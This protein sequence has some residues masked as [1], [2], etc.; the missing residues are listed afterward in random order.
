MNAIHDEVVNCLEELPVFKVIKKYTPLH[1]RDMTK[2]QLVDI[3]PSNAK[4]SWNKSDILK[5]VDRAYNS[6]SD[7]FDKHGLELSR[8]KAGQLCLMSDT[9][10][11]ISEEQS[12]YLFA[13]LTWFPFPTGDRVSCTLV[14]LRMCLSPPSFG[15][16]TPLYSQSGNY[17]YGDN[18]FIYPLPTDQAKMR[19]KTLDR[20]KTA[21]AAIESV[22]D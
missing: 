13:G 21:L 1:F 9:L 10:N 11:K 15:L 22:S 8:L 20:W 6:A 17:G 3:L 5:E 12:V 7:Y 16:R 14:E 2:Q 4:V 19:H 18:Q